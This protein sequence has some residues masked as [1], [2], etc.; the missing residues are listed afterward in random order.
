MPDVDVK[1]FLIAGPELLI[2][3]LVQLSQVEKQEAL[4]FNK[5][6]RTFI[7]N[8]ELKA[9]VS[10]SGSTA[11]KVSGTVEY[12]GERKDGGKGIEMFL[13]SRSGNKVF[14]LGE[15][16]VEKALF[17]KRTLT[18]SEVAQTCPICKSVISSKDVT[19]QCPACGVSAHKDHLLEYIK[20]HGQCPK[21]GK[22]LTM[23]GKE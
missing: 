18:I 3:N 13:R 15:E 9:D 23:K 17:S 2:Q 7:I 1:N 8:N 12:I 14:V 21:C 19:I 10:S 22:R 16:N 20:I 4:S 6:L 5:V 11:S